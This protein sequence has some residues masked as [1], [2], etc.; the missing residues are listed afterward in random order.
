M[1]LTNDLHR[2]ML[3][4]AATVAPEVTQPPYLVRQADLPGLPVPVETRAYC[5]QQPSP[6]TTQ[7]LRD[8]DLWR[9]PAPVIIFVEPLTD[10]LEAYG[11]FLH[12]LTHILPFSPVVER[13]TTP[14]ELSADTASVAAWAAEGNADMGLPRWAPHHGRHYLRIVSHLWHRTLDLCCLDVPKRYILHWEYDL[15]PLSAY[16]DVLMPEL[17]STDPNT[18]FADI[19]AT[20]EPDAFRVLFNQDKAAWL[21]WRDGATI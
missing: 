6:A 4:I 19:L 9:R 5:Q 18:P 3:S 15:L 14:A 10:R 11:R 16:I 13:P 20:P 17:R 1:R 8:A 2:D 21:R 12:E 7:A